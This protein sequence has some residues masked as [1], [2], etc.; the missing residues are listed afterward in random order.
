MRKKYQADEQ[1]RLKIKSPENP[2]SQIWYKV[3][4]AK[5]DGNT[6]PFAL[7]LS[8]PTLE[9]CDTS[10]IRDQSVDNWEVGP[11]GGE[12]GSKANLRLDLD[13]GEELGGFAKPSYGQG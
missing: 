3:T 2:N 10:G 6:K 13:A 1:K 8:L 5:D 12:L 4:A 9:A 11:K 7:P